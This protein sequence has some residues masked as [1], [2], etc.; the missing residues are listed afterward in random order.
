MQ[1][2]T[3]TTGK[4]KYR[5]AACLLGLSA[6]LPSRLLGCM[7]SGSFLHPP[8]T[9]ALTSWCKNDAHGALQQEQRAHGTFIVFSLAVAK[10]VFWHTQ[11][12]PHARSQIILR[13]PSTAYPSCP[14]R[15]RLGAQS[16]QIEGAEVRLRHGVEAAEDADL[17]LLARR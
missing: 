17:A 15:C 7:V 12:S 11:H 5:C 8:S 1:E 9:T 16:E 10:T 13:H 6:S 2:A 4:Y 3:H 14:C